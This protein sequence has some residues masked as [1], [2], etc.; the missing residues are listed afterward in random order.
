MIEEDRPLRPPIDRPTLR[1]MVAPVFI[2]VLA[3]VAAIGG[4]FIGR[5]AATDAYVR[6]VAPIVA[7]ET[8]LETLWDGV[9]GSL[10]DPVNVRA[11]AAIY[12][13]PADDRAGLAERLRQIPWVPPYRPAPFVGH[14]GRAYDSAT[15][16]VNAEG[17]RDV[18]RDYSSKP[19]GTVRV[20][21][22]GGSTA[23]GSG[24]VQADT[25]ANALERIL[26]ARVAP[27]TRLRY[28]V[29]NAAFP[30]WSTT[31]EKIFIQQRLVDM[32][33]DVIIMF[34]GNND[35]HWATQRADIRWFS[36]TP[37]QLRDAPQRAS[38]SRAP[39][40]GARRSADNV[41]SRRLCR[42]RTPRGAQYRGGG[43][44]RGFRQEPS[45]IRAAAQSGLDD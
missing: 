1:A 7:N 17:L 21:V 31:Q 35:V 38:S 2:S 29:V 33:P 20:F 5:H 22:T 41:G 13:V 18:E 27:A 12:G 32:H 6:K 15:L 16:H 14:M 40:G 30:A 26:N 8:A 24:S 45:D 37:T 19:A 42:C 34:S 10:D 44:F 39:S 3:A 4:F 23:W 43:A 28:E 11:L 25:I 36:P 9:H